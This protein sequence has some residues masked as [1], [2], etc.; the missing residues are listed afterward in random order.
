MPNSKLDILAEIR[1]NRS[2]CVEL[3][4]K[5]QK[6]NINC[7]DVANA[8]SKSG[9]L[10][11]HFVMVFCKGPGILELVKFLCRRHPRCVQSKTDRDTLPIN[12][13]PPT[14][15]PQPVIDAMQ[16]DQM[17]ARL[18]LMKKYPE[19]IRMKDKD[20][21]TPLVRAV[22]G[23]CNILADAMIARFPELARETNKKG[24]LP[25][26]YAMET[27]NAGAV[28][29]LYKAHPEGI[30]VADHMGVTPYYIFFNLHDKDPVI[31]ALVDLMCKVF[32]IEDAT[33]PFTE[34]T[35]STIYKQALPQY[36]IDSNLSV[37][38]E[39]VVWRLINN[40]TEA[41]TTPPPEVPETPRENSNRRFMFAKSDEIRDSVADLRKP[42]TPRS[43]Q[44]HTKKGQFEALRASFETAAKG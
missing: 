10:P 27:A 6:A 33:R 34:E 37:W 3:L 19:A 41:N 18:Y 25:L 28:N 9:W 29:I 4:Q 21:E 30:D 14:T 42:R 22:I 20:G 39:K 2:N 44:R 23:R 13:M 11:L 26:H 43:F 8:K 40:W 12:L 36:A 31:A 32:E 7:E 24:R 38:T 15:N 5:F 17:D 16:R 35:T 1:K